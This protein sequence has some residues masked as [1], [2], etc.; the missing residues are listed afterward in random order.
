MWISS[1]S[2]GTG[3]G[4][5][6]KFKNIFILYINFNMLQ[7][8]ENGQV[9]VKK[10]DCPYLSVIPHESIWRSLKFPRD[11]CWTEIRSTALLLIEMSLIHPWNPP[12]AF[13]HLDPK[14]LSGQPDQNNTKQSKSGYI[15]MNQDLVSQTTSLWKKKRKR[16][17]INFLKW[18]EGGRAPRSHH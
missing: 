9:K 6:E 13:L 14:L 11:P 18:K 15:I 7:T 1:I 3:D 2:C 10:W 12:S 8:L 17:L 16:H 5:K 4:R